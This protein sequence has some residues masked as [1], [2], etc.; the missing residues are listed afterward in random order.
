MIT[1]VDAGRSGDD[2]AMLTDEQIASMTVSQRRDLMMR[3]ARPASQV[4]P[5]PRAIR[6]R[7]SLVVSGLVLGVA[8]LI[9]WTSYLA[10]TL[11]SHYEARNWDVAWVGFD[12]LLIAMLAITAWLG[13]RRR[14]LV[15]LTAFATGMLLVVDAWF[16]VV[17]AQHADRPLSILVAVVLELPV[18]GLMMT[19]SVQMIMVVAA[20]LWMRPPGSRVWQVPMIA[21]VGA[22]TETLGSLVSFR[23]P[24]TEPRSSDH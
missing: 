24:A 2:G 6:R 8:M 23:R 1:R 13:W 19:M 10:F 9:P 5:S 12:V 22:D 7:R 21:F 18:A 16:D 14:Q 20:R 3:L 17:T 15:A 11:P 4:L